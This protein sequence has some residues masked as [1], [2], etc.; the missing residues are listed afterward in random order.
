MNVY[1]LQQGLLTCTLVYIVGAG[2]VRGDRAWSSVKKAVAVL[3]V[4][5]F[6]ITFD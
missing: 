6:L 4:T 1:M 3:G 2:D 5:L